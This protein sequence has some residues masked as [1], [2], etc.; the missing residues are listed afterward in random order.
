MYGSEYRKNFALCSQSTPGVL[1]EK[2]RQQD[3]QQ[4]R[5]KIGPTSALIHIVIMMGVYSSTLFECIDLKLDG[6]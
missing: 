2:P 3:R 6:M 1:S 5:D 4:G